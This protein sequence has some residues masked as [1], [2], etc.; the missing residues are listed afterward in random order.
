MGPIRLLSVFVTKLNFLPRFLYSIVH[1]LLLRT[2]L[3]Q[4]RTM[5][6]IE[7]SIK[8]KIEQFN[9][10]KTPLKTCELMLMAIE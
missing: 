8:T 1:V 10:R 9:A 2:S 7:P 4:L 3:Q 6:R 5:S